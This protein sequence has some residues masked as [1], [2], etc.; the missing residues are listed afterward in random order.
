VADQGRG[1]MYSCW[2]KSGAHKT[3]WMNKTLKFIDRA[4]SGPPDV[5]VKCPCSRCTNALH[6]DK[7]T[8]TLHLCKFGFMLGYEVWMHHGERV[9]QWLKRR[10]IGA[11][12]IG[13]MRCLMLYDQ[14]LKQTT[15]ILQH[16][17]CKSFSI[18]LELQKTR[19]MNTRQ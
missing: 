9:H 4:L 12:I 3:E 13:W 5:G 16:R 7:R 11:V 18:C 8:L 1:W 2:K 19:C 17:R 6:Q 10:M 14:S 15:R